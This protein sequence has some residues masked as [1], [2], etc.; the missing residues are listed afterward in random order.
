MEGGLCPSVHTTLALHGMGCRRA[1]QGKP[2][3][4]LEHLPGVRTPLLWGPL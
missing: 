2:M 4:L 1:A 3:W